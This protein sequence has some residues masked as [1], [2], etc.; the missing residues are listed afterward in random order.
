MNEIL[1][2]GEQNL[3]LLEA[4]IDAFKIEGLRIANEGSDDEFL[5]FEN[6][7]EL[8]V[9]K[10]RDKFDKLVLLESPSWHNLIGSTLPENMT[11]SLSL[12]EER[13]VL[14]FIVST[15]KQETQLG[16]IDVSPDSVTHS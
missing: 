11:D 8:I 14:E 16:G 3:E 5:N 10:I 9:M 7:K 4:Y 15:I 2:S 6:T 13:A 1:P 12:H